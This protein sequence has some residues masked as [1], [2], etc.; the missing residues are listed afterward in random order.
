MDLT[1]SKWSVILL[2]VSQTLVFI[3]MYI[4]D[5]NFSLLGYINRS[6]YIASIGLFLSLTIYTINTGFFDVVTRSF[7]LLFAGKDVTRQNVDEMTPL[8]EIISINYSPL[9]IV[10]LSNLLLSLLALY[11]Y[12]H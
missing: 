11:V 10:G 9:F 1:R 8:S 6:F 7:R 5:G 3:L 12:N 4:L 2:I